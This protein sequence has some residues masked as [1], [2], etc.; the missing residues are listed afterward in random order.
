MQ[1]LKLKND[2]YWTGIV[3]RGL[4]VFDIIMATEFGTTY[5]SYVLK[6][7]DQTILF[8]T[9]KAKFFDEYLKELEGITDIESI[10]YLVVDHTE[11]DHAG[12][13]EFLL[14]RNPNMKIIATGCAINF[15]K[16]IVNRDFYSIPVKDNETM[17]IGTKTLRFMAVP[18]LH[19]PDTMYTYIK[20]DKILVTCDSFGAHYGAEGILR[21]QVKNEADY[22]RALKYYFDCIM[23]PF[24]PY[25]LKAVRRVREME[26]DLICTGH[27]PV[28]D[29]KIQETLDLCEK[30]S[31]VENP[32]PG[33]TVIIPYVSAYGYTE[34]LAHEIREGIRESGPVAVRCYDMVE[35]NQTKVLEELE[36]AD[37]ILFGTPTIL[38]EA[39]KPIWDLT[40]SICSITHSGKTASAFGSYGWS[41]EGVPHMIER[42]K[43][44]KM[45]VPDYGFRVKF[46]P[47]EVDLMEAREYGYRFGCLVQGKDPKKKRSG[48]KKLV[49]CLVCGEI[50]DAAL[51]TCPVCGVGREFFVEVNADE[52]TYHHDSKDCFVIL[53]NG[54]A[55][56]SAAEAVRERNRTASIVMISQEPFESYNR[57]MLTKSM[58]A[59]MTPEQIA[60]HEEAWY[61]ERS[62]T[63]VLGSRVVKIDSGERQVILEDGRKLTY[64]KLIY[65]L[66]AECF[67]PPI[68][69][70]DRERVL[71]VRTLS[72]VQKINRLLP[73]SR[74]IAVIGGGVLGLET[75][76]EFK[77]SKCEVT[78]IEA[79]PRLMMR[80]LDEG[81][82]DLL[83]RIAASEG[84][85]VYTD[86]KVEALEGDDTSGAQGAVTGVLLED[87]SRIEADL[88]ILSAGIRANLSLAGDL[89]LAVGCGVVVNE[90]ME[91]NVEDVYACGDCAEYDGRNYGIWPVAVEQGKTAGANA[92]GDELE[93]EVP[94]LGV[95]FHGMNTALFSIGDIGANENQSYRTVEIK[96]E[97]KK[98]YEKYYY[99][100]S[101]LRGAILIGDLSR[102]AELVTEIQG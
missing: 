75:A 68:K 80:Q 78:V 62:I 40:T 97:A 70:A 36:F 41:G 86:T 45:K 13:V 10:N 4:R 77:K 50:F 83:E 52:I 25:M 1:T 53:G 29:T 56:L 55:G 101:Q 28:L 63:R 54:A 99:V 5:N 57:P 26:V 85:T 94:S 7:G 14:D 9:A 82:G 58:M 15:L 84:I 46:K 16:N 8:E 65:A 33:K 35:S 2:F 71:S 89:G 17:T 3:D 24:K 32:N 92:A 90:K 61:E 22:Q 11:P 23:G 43:Q 31:I 39:L 98:K 73:D 21:S 74:R 51:D 48:V 44:L 100:N 6:A 20:E 87:G 95:S 66:G 34:A 42:L 102:M 19:W 96:D 37:G 27:G 76:W 38:G 18:N 67:I 88:V 72:D 49:K 12:S 69:G 64:T 91:T 59:G 47:G 60:V 93:Y 30:W 81:A 79:A